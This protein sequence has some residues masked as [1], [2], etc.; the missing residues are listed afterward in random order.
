[1]SQIIDIIGGQ[2]CSKVDEAVLCFVTIESIG[3]TRSYTFFTTPMFM[4]FGG[5]YSVIL[6]L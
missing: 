1:M 6:A 3:C 2:L 5:S 4:H